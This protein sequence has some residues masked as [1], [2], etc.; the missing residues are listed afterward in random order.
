MY[1]DDTLWQ[2]ELFVRATAKVEEKYLERNRDQPGQKAQYKHTHSLRTQGVIGLEFYMR[3][4]ERLATQH[5]VMRTVCHKVLISFKDITLLTPIWK[6][7]MDSA[8]SAT[9]VKICFV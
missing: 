4:N 8:I 5:C 6:N 2:C 7:T 9:I 1:H 3:R